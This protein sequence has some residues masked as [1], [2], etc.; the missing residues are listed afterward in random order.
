MKGMGGVPKMPKMPTI[1]GKKPPTKK[2]KKPVAASKMVITV[3]KPM[4]G[5]GGGGHS[6]HGM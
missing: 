5:T 2:G 3:G 4:G 1:Q 6:G